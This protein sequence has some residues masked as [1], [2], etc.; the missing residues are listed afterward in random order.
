MKLTP[1]SFVALVIQQIANHYKLL[2]DEFIC[3]TVA[4]SKAMEN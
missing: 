3:Y 2:K 4:L 1:E